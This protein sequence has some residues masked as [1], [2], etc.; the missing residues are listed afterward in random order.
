MTR[1]RAEKRSADGRWD[2]LR[3]GALALTA[4]GVV[5]AQARQ[6]SKEGKGEETD[7]GSPHVPGYR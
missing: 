2:T 6:R 4:I 7:G 5:S 3:A 1:K